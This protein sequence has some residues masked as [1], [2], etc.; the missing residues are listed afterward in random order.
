MLDE[1]VEADMVE[2]ARRFLRGDTLQP[3]GLTDV[4]GS[5]D[6]SASDELQRDVVTT[7]SPDIKQRVF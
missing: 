7:S 4:I 6:V 3:P 5:F 2:C 1:E